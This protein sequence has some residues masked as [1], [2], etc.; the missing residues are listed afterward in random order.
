VL[1]QLQAIKE[2]HNCFFLQKNPNILQRWI[3]IRPIQKRPKEINKEKKYNPT[4]YYG[5]LTNH[6]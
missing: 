5:D 4:S 2:H 6:I 1:C 3:I